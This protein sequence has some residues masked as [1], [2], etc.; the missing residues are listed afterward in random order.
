MK[1]LFDFGFRKFVTPSIIKIV[2]IL[3]MIMLVVSYLGFTIAAFNE[4]AIFG[5]LVLLVLGPLFVLIYLVF[6][7][8]CLESLIAQIRT[9]ENTSELVRLAGGTPPN[10]LSTGIV[11]PNPAG[12]STTNIRPANQA[13]PTRPVNRQD[14]EDGSTPPTNPYKS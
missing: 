5:L 12:P 6:A 4:D 8:A 14:P 7:R 3:I 2:Y 13:D 10:E 11:P 9:A 1:A